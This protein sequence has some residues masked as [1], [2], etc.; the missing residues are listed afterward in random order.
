MATQEQLD[1]VV[2][3]H[4]L[5]DRTLLGYDQSQGQYNSDSLIGGDP[6]EVYFAKLLGGTTRVSTFYV[7]TISIFQGEEITISKVV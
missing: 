3:L 2:K 6:Y 7:K 1:S 5:N 4:E